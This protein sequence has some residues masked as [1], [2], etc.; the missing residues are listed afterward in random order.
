M[1]EYL[2]LLEMEF[3]AD[4]AGK[5]PHDSEWTLMGLPVKI[6]GKIKC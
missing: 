3:A 6:K 2:E 4:P 1:D 5:Y